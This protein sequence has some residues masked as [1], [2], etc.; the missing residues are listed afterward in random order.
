MLG[1]SGPLQRLIAESRIVRIA[2][3]TPAKV[4]AR[5]DCS[6]SD[7]RSPPVKGETLACTIF[8][9]GESDRRAV[10][11]GAA[12]VAKLWRMRLAPNGPNIEE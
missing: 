9:H 1:I 11:K 2:V 5:R 10:R 8:I 3:F 7:K 6:P 4:M 12:M